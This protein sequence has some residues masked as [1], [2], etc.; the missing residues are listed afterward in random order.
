MRLTRPD[1]DAVRRKKYKED[2]TG[3]SIFPVLNFLRE[4]DFIKFL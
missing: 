2:R 3:E 4:N 1:R